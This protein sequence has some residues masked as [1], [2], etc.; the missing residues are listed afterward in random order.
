MDLKNPNGFEGI[1]SSHFGWLSGQSGFTP[2]KKQLMLICP[3]HA[4]IWNTEYG[5]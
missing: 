2:A 4:Q 5:N 3:D 1:N